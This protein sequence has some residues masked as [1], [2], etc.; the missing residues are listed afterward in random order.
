M[1]DN[2]YSGKEA[3]DQINNVLTEIA[4]K[5]GLGDEI[6]WPKV[7]AVVEIP[8]M[9]EKDNVME[10]AGMEMEKGMEAMMEAT[11]FL[12]PADFGESNGPTKFPKLVLECMAVN[13]YFYDLV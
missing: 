5:G 8:E 4:T 13:P 6:K 9:M 2:K 3:I 7:E 12:N 11:K 10:G 1:V